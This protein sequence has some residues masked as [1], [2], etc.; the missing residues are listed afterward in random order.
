MSFIFISF[1]LLEIYL[2]I[3]TNYCE[4][5]FDKKTKI[6]KR[7]SKTDGEY[8]TRYTNSGYFRINNEGWNSHRD[9]FKRNFK[10]SAKCRIAIIGHSNIE[11]LRV[12][13]SNTLS[14]VLED[15]LLNNGI[16][17]EVYTFGHG[18]MHLAQALHVSRY[19]VR[20]FDPDIIAIGTFIDNFLY[21]F[22]D[23]E[24]FVALNINNDLVREI[25]PVKY[26]EDDSAL[27]FLYFS[28]V[29]KY[30]DIKLGIS[31]RIKHQNSECLE[32]NHYEMLKC[33]S[34]TEKVYK[35]IKYILKEFSDLLHAS[36]HKKRRLYFMNFPVTIPSDN[37]EKPYSLT[38]L[39]K[40]KRIINGL[41][42]EHQF[43]II[44]LKQAFME[45]YSIHLKRFDFP[46]DAHYNEHA[47]RVIG[48]YLANYFMKNVFNKE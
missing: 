46:N 38:Y 7:K 36:D 8:K 4:P 17:A 34:Y 40:H 48:S 21:N 5:W 1:V 25:F 31:E 15:E 29:L 16:N 32:Q 45:D 26:K 44:N 39:S 19:V 9:Y 35:G 24:N 18:G 23:K 27:S 43:P 12:S 13:Y 11:G 30:I 3:F 10:D 2:R 47:H 42:I 41:I 20:E 28:K 37:E 22:T 6:I 14:K 33:P